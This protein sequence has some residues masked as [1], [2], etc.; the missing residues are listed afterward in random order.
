[1]NIAP[2]PGNF[3]V[4]ITGLDLTQPPSREA[5]DAIINALY[6]HLV[7]C[8]R[9]QRLSP[10]EFAKLGRCLGDPVVHVETDLLVD[11]TPEV[12]VLSNA[13]NRSERQRNGGFHWHTDLVFTE[14]PASFTMLNAI[15][16]PRVGGQTRFANQ[17]AAYDALPKDLRIGA[18]SL[19]VMHCYEGRQD[20]SFPTV[21]HP[22]VRAHPITGR[23][24]LY[25][26][27]STC[28]GIDG[29]PEQEGIELLQQYRDYALAPSV[30]YTHQYETDD[31]VIWD[32]AAMLHTGPKLEPAGGDVDPRIM[33]RISVR[34]WPE[35][36]QASTP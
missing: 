29:M 35:P 6:Q 27:N 4:Q 9:Q 19:T 17:Y 24:A 12:M 3:G 18:E 2:L 28:I 26:A 22:L 15:A 10:V 36:S 14:T 1:M 30:Q 8:I 16:V 5:L 32:N 7:V 31:V 33:H 13:D 20:G 21:L 34:G 11:G 23:K 25:G